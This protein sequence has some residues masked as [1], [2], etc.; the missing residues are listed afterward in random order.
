MF[1]Y[2]KGTLVDKIFPYCS[3]EVNNIA[4]KDADVNTNYHTLTALA[5]IHLPLG[6]AFCIGQ[7]QIS[8]SIYYTYF[9]G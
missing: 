3:V 4:Y 2:F 9:R 5:A 8:I 6:T 7:S 1:D